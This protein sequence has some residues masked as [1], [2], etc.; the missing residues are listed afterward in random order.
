MCDIIE[1]IKGLDVG[2]STW[3][4]V[5]GERDTKYFFVGKICT[6]PKSKRKVDQTQRSS[7][8]IAVDVHKFQRQGGVMLMG[9]SNARVGKTDNR[10]Y[11]GNTDKIRTQMV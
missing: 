1:L 11:S 9:H 3:R 6:H 4:R 2:E 5:S 10:I 7:G 8:E